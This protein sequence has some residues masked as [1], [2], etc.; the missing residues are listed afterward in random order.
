MTLL[1]TGTVLD[2]IAARTRKDVEDRKGLYPEKLL[3]QSIHFSA[4]TVSLSHYIQRPDKSGVIAEFKRK[5]PSEP[6]IH[7]YADPE[8][9]TIGYM[10]AGASALSVLT[11]GPFFGGSTSDLSV[12]RTFNYCPILRKDF[13]LDEYQ[14]IEARSIGADAILLIAELLPPGRIAA[15]AKLARALDLEV[16]MET[17]SAE[18]L[19]KLCDDVTLCGINTRNLETFAIHLEVAEELVDR[20]PAGLV[21]VAESGMRTPED[22]HRLRRAGFEGF[23]IGSQFMRQPHPGQACR[24]FIRKLAEHGL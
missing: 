2:Q 23:L 13:I 20:I 14:V 19:D 6:N 3:E 8:Q 16:L 18:G 15:L 5:S 4:P 11:D 17:H 9:V 1:T 10:Q 21:K 22:V 24:Q 7:L 12:A